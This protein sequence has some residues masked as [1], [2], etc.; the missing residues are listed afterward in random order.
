M[1]SGLNEGQWGHK[2]RRRLT[3][4]NGKGHGLE[5]SVILENYCSH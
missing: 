5:V 2:D 4:E 1:E 3:V